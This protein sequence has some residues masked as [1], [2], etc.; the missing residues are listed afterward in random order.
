M[1]GQRE[2]EEKMKLSKVIIA[3]AALDFSL[4]AIANIDITP[5]IGA[6][7]KWAHMEFQ[8]RLGENLTKNS[9]LQD[10]LFAGVKLN[11]WVGFEAGYETT[12]K[13]SRTVQ[14][15]AGDPFY[16]RAY[17]LLPTISA[18]T[19]TRIDGFNASVVGFLPIF[20]EHRLSLL[21]S[22][23]YANLK[24]HTTTIFPSNGA[25]FDFKKK[26]W[27]PRV[28]VGIQQMVSDQFGI[29]VSAGWENTSKF[30][31]IST[32]NTPTSLNAK[33]NNLTNFGLGLFYH[34]K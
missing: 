7:A 20:E 24:I 5:Y 11:E 23:G 19:E 10:N 16:G 33:V 8:K 12:T 14:V 3:V 21:G 4:S 18:T 9:Y 27:I 34:F 2:R 1:F 22:I 29:R 17:P 15:S 30:N 6:D 32:V 13:Q 31:K 25:R 26:A 28:T